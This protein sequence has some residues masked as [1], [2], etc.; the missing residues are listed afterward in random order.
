MSPYARLIAHRWG[1]GQVTLPVSDSGGTQATVD[2]KRRQGEDNYRDKARPVTA[3][4]MTL[5]LLLADVRDQ[6][7]T[8]EQR[9]AALAE[10]ITEAVR[11][12]TDLDAAAVEVAAA[13]GRP[14]RTLTPPRPSATRRCGK[15]W[16]PDAPPG[17]RTSG[18]RPPRLPL[19]RRWLSWKPPNPSGSGY[20]RS[21]TS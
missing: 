7:V 12:A 19:K 15:R 8:H 2:I 21:E 16:R 18:P 4:R 1:K 3:A 14:A 6:V 10:R 20:V 9:M 11:T 13:I 17:R 5:E